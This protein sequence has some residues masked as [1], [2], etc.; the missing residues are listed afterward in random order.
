MSTAGDIIAA[1]ALVVAL[2]G[3]LT[4][5]APAAT[6]EWDVDG[7]A[8]G[9][10]GGSGTWDNLGNTNWWDGSTNVQWN[11]AGADQAEFDG[12]PG[13]VTL[14]SDVT[15]DK[16]TFYDPYTIDGAFTLTVGANG[17]RIAPG[18]QDAVIDVPVALSA[19]QSWQV[20]GG[21]NDVHVTQPVS[22]S[23]GWIKGGVGSVTLSGDNSGYSGTFTI[24]QGTVVIGSNTPFGSATF[25]FRGASGGV[26]AFGSDRLVDNPLDLFIGA[27]QTQTN[28]FGGTHD[29]E[30][31][32]TL[33]LRGGI[34]PNAWLVRVVDPM[35]TTFSGDVTES[36]V[37]KSLYKE[38]PGRFVFDGTTV[39]YTGATEVREGTLIM[40][41]ATSGQDGYTVGDAGNMV[42]GALGGTGAIGLKAGQSVDVV[43]GYGTLT[44]GESIGTLT[45]DGAVRLDGALAVDID[46]TDAD[47]LD[48][49]GLLALGSASELE[50][51]V[52]GA[53]DPAKTYKI[54]EYAELSG[55]F[56]TDNVPVSHSLDYGL[57]LDDAIR[58]LPAAQE[59]IPEPASALPVGLGALAVL[60]RRRRH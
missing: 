59:V 53:M 15:A 8:S 48:V 37:S 40:N 54:A 30:F 25:N 1:A 29:L 9:A 10:Q 33:P 27:G 55:T 21:S 20:Q 50:L 43:A 31:T 46:A 49:S 52:A 23:A 5:G 12:G 19:N 24:Q 34:R 38:G 47:L 18:N 22:G 13:T 41:A 35:T 58:L 2:A 3:A 39:G 36:N 57:G 28:T 44:P 14:G 6:L 56:G 45:V 11:N 17:V 51:L 4:A 32:A 26:R 7:T 60:R 42:S 16:V